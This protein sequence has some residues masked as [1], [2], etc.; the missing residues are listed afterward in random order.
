MPQITLESVSTYF[1]IDGEGPL[2]FLLLNGAGCTTETWGELADG[3]CR[4]GQVIRFDARGC[5]RTGLP[6]EEYTLETLAAD[7]LALI[8]YLKVQKAV[9]VGHAFG[10]RV[11]QILSRD[12][13][14]RTS[15]LVLCGTGGFYPPRTDDLPLDLP[16]E[17]AFLARFC[18]PRFRDEQPEAARRLLDEVFAQRPPREAAEYRARALAATPAE[19]YWGTTPNSVRTLLLYGTEDR[20]GH[21]DNAR[22]LAGRLENSRLVFIEGAGHFA[23]REAPARLLTEITAFIEEQQ[24]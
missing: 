8:D 24:P 9:L 2:V 16:R 5:G 7:A 6:P 19:T 3:L 4:L 13:A 22:D 11:A 12:Y 15:A 18:G 14:A 10:G 20:F 1:R 17:D 23:I 21:P